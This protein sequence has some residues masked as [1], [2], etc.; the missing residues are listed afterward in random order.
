[1]GDIFGIVSEC[2]LWSDI[3]KSGP[4]SSSSPY[5]VS[6]YNW[7]FCRNFSKAHIFCRQ[8]VAFFLVLETYKYTNGWVLTLS[9]LGKIFSRWHFEIFFSYF[10]QKTGFDI[11]CKLCRMETICMKC[12]ILFSGKNKKNITNLSSAKLIKRVLK[13]KGKTLAFHLR[14]VS[15]RREVNIA[16]QGWIL[17]GFGGFDWA[18][19]PPPPLD[20]KFHFLGKF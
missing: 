15:M 6:R 17:R 19:P 5:F 10:S 11:S 3:A 18:S 14:L 7:R 1:M 4:I 9:T 2:T 12:Q 8:E 20:S 16:M 13:V